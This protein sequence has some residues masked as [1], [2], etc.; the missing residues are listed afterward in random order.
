MDVASRGVD[1]VGDGVEDD[2]DDDDGYATPCSSNLEV[3]C[4]LQRLVSRM[5]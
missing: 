3:V 1:G 5:L 4:C 2:D